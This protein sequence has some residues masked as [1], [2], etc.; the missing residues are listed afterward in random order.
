MKDESGPEKEIM[1]LLAPK[2]E[3]ATMKMPKEKREKMPKEDRQSKAERTI[4]RSEGER[5]GGR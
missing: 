4:E 3:G 2:Q 5:R 1:S